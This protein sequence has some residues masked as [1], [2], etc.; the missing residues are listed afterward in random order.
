MRIRHI[1]LKELRHRW[2]TSLVILSAIVL[3]VGIIVLIFRVQ[4]SSLAGLRRTLD[5]MG[6]NIVILHEDVILS[7]YFTGH[8]GEKVF[9]HTHAA[10]AVRVDPPVLERAQTFYQRKVTFT[11]PDNPDDPDGWVEL[12]LCGVGRQKLGE[13]GLVEPWLEEGEAELGSTAAE[14]LEGHRVG[15]RLL[16]PYQGLAREPAAEAAV[17][18]PTGLPPH[19]RSGPR[20]PRRVRTPAEVRVRKI[21]ERTGTI[22]DYMVFVDL[23]V[24]R[25]LYGLVD[26]DTHKMRMVVNVVEGVAKVNPREGDVG[27]GDVPADG[28]AAAA[29]RADERDA[30]TKTVE[31]IQARAKGTGDPGVK[32]YAMRGQA[33][34]RARAIRSRSQRMHLVAVG[35]FVLGALLVAGY[36]VVNVRQRRKEMGVLLAIAARPNHVRRMFLEKMLILAVLGGV[37]GS[38]VG[39]AAAVHWG[40]SGTA[41]VGPWTTYGL[42]VLIALVVTL[43]PSLAGVFVASRIDPVD[44]LRD[45]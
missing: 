43:L 31:A 8:L 11:D 41:F 37:V 39:S 38:A 33:R 44:T 29:P 17:E 35:V 40:P 10:I 32:V 27:Y 21:R 26:P 28:L 5:Q 18:K 30:I 2:A 22:K 25:R 19:L 34:A 36:T 15:N 16:I 23:N 7:D 20:Q 24:A 3:C 1:V 42:A 6:N 13:A 14:R 4:Q 45:L 9:P 12:V